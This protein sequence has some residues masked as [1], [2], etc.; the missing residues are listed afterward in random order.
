MKRPIARLSSN[1]A[2]LRT[3][4][5]GRGNREDCCRYV[6]GTSAAARCGFGKVLEPGLDFV[7]SK[8]GTRDNHAAL[9]PCCPVRD[10]A[11]VAELTKRM[12]R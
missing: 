2:D 5:H 3:A 4:R 11:R 6:L 12:G 10:L 8:A 9:Q 7:D 1:R